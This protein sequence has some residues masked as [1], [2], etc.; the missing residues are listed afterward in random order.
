MG[1]TY[2]WDN[3]RSERKSERSV[4]KG[5]KKNTKQCSD[6]ATSR[7]RKDEYP[8]LARPNNKNAVTTGA[9]KEKAI[10]KV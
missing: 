10:K 3:E 1:K 7:L 9:E 2:S 6:K 4:K 5:N 8:T